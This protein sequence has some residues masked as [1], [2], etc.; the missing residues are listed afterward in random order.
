MKHIFLQTLR[1]VIALTLTVS[2]SHAQQ[3][4]QI[5]TADDQSA[6]FADYQ[7]SE[8]E[9]VSIPAD[10]AS[11]SKGLRRSVNP[12]MEIT[13][14]LDE[15]PEH[16][17]L[18]QF[19]LLDANRVTPEMAV[20]ANDLMAGMVQL[21]GTGG[22][23][24]NPYPWK[25]TYQLYIPAEMLTEGENTLRLEAPRPLYHNEDI[26]PYLWW[27]WD[28]LQLSAL[29][30]PADEPVHGSV[31][32]MGSTMKKGENNFTVDQ[33]L[34][35]LT[36]VVLD[37]LGIGH[38]GNTMRADFW[39]DV[40]SKQTS[41]LELLEK[42]QEYN[43]T[44]I[45]THLNSGQAQGR[46]VDGQLST[47][48]QTKLDNFF[49]A[50]GSL[51]QYH[52]VD[53]EPGLFN[54]TKE[55]NVAIA[56]YVNQI[57]PNYV[58]TTAPGWAYWKNTWARDPT[59]RLEVEQLCQATNGHAY[60]TSFAQPQGGNLSANLLTYGG[61]T[62]GWP[63]EMVVTENG[64]NDSHTGWSFLK[65]D[66][67]H[68]S[69]FDAIMRAHIS[70]TD[71]FM[72]HATVFGKFSLFETPTWSNP[73]SL[74][75]WPGIKDEDPRVKTF[76]RLALA[77][78][79]HGA[80]VGYEVLNKDE[81]SGKKV[82]FR[83]VDTSTLPPLKGNGHTSNKI[84]INFVNFEATE[85]TLS[86]RVDLPAGSYEGQRFGPGDSYQA[87]Q[88]NVTLAV[89]SALVLT[90]TLG[91]GEAVQYILPGG[92]GG[93][94][95]YAPEAAFVATPTQGSSPL[96]VRFDAS[97][98][99]DADGDV[100]TYTWN[101]GDGSTGSGDS[102]SHTYE[103]DENQVFTAT[104]TVSDG[105]DTSSQSLDIEV[106]PRVADLIV[107]DIYWDPS[108]PS[109][110][111]AVQFAAKITNRGT[112]PTLAGTIVGVNF[113]VDG[114]QIAWSDYSTTALE[115]GESRVLVANNSPTGSNTWTLTGGAQAVSAQVDDIR[116][117]GEADDTNNTRTEP[118]TNDGQS[119]N[120]ASSQVADLIVTAVTW[121]PSSPQAGQ[122]VR[123]RATVENVG[124]TPTP[125]G[126]TIGVSFQVDGKQVAWSDNVSEALAAGASRVL[127]ANGSPGEGGG[128]WG[129]DPAADSVQAY[130]DDIGRIGEADD[131]NNRLK[132][133]LSNSPAPSEETDLVVTAIAWE[134]GSPTA[135]DSVRF[136]A[137]VQNI[138]GQ[139]TPAG[140]ILGVEFKVDGEQVA[141]SDDDTT[142]LGAGQSRTLVASGGPDGNA[143][144]KFDPAAD[145]VQAYVNDVKRIPE[146]DRSNNR[147]KVAL[148]SGNAP[149]A[150]SGQVGMGNQRN[151]SEP[152]MYPNPASNTVTVNLFLAVTETVN[153]AVVHPSG[154]VV[155]EQTVSPQRG[156]TSVELDVSSLSPG[157]YLV[158]TQAAQDQYVTRKL[159]IE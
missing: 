128:T 137:T 32:Y 139:A 64:T 41:R 23:A 123:F 88:S 134:P 78:A 140:A 115:A 120:I 149:A 101:F 22:G 25:K 69:A 136:R 145:S 108:S 155:L 1:G 71:R 53:N 65:P 102:L 92:Q 121:E 45:T 21:W 154:Q 29:T 33:E 85:Q 138:G 91:P 67:P 118:L 5:G 112:A 130:V 40:S 158:R 46:L 24:E 60:D 82:Y 133:A 48:D 94:G 56:R 55:V 127:V 47:T 57:K 151:L 141:W 51:F 30:E 100:L 105:Q 95:N 110:G 27:E 42:F 8:L 9:T 59:Q 75:A 111:Q 15:V 81:V 50:Y 14:E 129:F 58:K 31:V 38:S 107:E 109:V 10:A 93:R 70:A 135:G 54:R 13:F 156:S 37:W 43:M 20:F 74:T 86:V 7:A 39:S 113:K 2:F 117:I 132:V 90:E 80:P 122:A 34:V 62:D 35:N 106:N 103:A 16:G 28:Y 72:Q 6:E 26:D 73:A 17:T 152:S 36:P 114:Q 77:Y 98:S 148:T 18:L 79:T 131:S 144:W 97:T 11:V 68:A 89:D 49:D 142:S 124:N 157:V 4:W 19:K 143:T 159:I 104:L 147:L 12:M 63:K 3:L 116:R 44:V 153:I 61:V 125:E 99:Y 83:G 150:L 126:T 84:L 76:R 96:T 66:Q 146:A 52:E 119:E 87:S